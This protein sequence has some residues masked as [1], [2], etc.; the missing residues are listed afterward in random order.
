PWPG[1]S[2][3]ARRTRHSSSCVRRGGPAGARG[4]EQADEVGGVARDLGVVAG[5]QAAGLVVALEEALMGPTT[6]GLAVAARLRGEVELVRRDPD[7]ESL[8]RDGLE[9][10]PLEPASGLDELL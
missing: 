4:D 10:L 1:P 2:S 6:V 9:G 7:L 3:R 5:L 8:A